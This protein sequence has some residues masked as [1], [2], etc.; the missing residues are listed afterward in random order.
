MLGKKGGLK[1]IILIIVIVLVLAIFL[2]MG[3]KR[4]DTNGDNNSQNRNNDSSSAVNDS[5]IFSLKIGESATFN[6]K[7]IILKNISS[8]SQITLN[9]DFSP[10]GDYFFYVGFP[11]VTLGR[12]LVVELV[13]VEVINGVKVAVLNIKSPG[14][15]TIF[16]LMKDQAGDY[17]GVRITVEE[18]SMD[19][20]VTVR[21]EKGVVSGQY[22]GRHTFADGETFRGITIGD[23]NTGFT[24]FAIKLVRIDT[25]G[26]ART[27]VLEVGAN[28]LFID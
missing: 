16:N 13:R 25:R 9:F 14:V 1:V 18:I 28:E 15:T 10:G 23:I 7:T 21:W 5:Q 19:N 20:Q 17:Q 4:S 26:S 27:A 6:G 24:S 11:P 12:D 22:S 2:F 8:D 3:L